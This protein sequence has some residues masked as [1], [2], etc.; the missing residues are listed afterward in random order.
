[1]RGIAQNLVQKD[2]HPR[3]IQGCMVG[4]NEGTC[5]KKMD[6]KCSNCGAA[7]KK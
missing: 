5:Q 7:I 1:L 2:V 4:T 3:T 6:E